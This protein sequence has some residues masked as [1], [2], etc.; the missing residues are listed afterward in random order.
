M[1]VI[2]FDITKTIGIMLVKK[3]MNAKKALE[4]AQRLCSRQ[5]KCSADIRLNLVRWGVEPKEIESIIAMLVREKYIDESRY[6][7]TFARDKARLNKWGP[8][9]IA[10]GLKAKGLSSD[11]VNIAL[12]EI[13]DLVTAESLMDLLNKKVKMVKHSSPAELRG[14][15]IRFGL[16]RGFE[17]SDVANA[18]ERITRK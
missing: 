3:R 14:K 15:L 1:W 2:A 18:A 11:N 4:R 16:S 12:A 13:K 6:A 5:E 17:Y 9:K 10:M 7:V 8:K